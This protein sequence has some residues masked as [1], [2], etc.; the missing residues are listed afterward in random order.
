M[1]IV[2]DQ[3]LFFILL[4]IS[5]LCLLIAVSASCTHSFSSKKGKIMCNLLQI[6]IWSK[7]ILL[8]LANLS[9]VSQTHPLLHN[10]EKCL[11]CN[12]YYFLSLKMT[13]DPVMRDL[14]EL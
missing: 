7:S 8:L 11:G 10:F 9:C 14:R 4:M 12:S 1:F 13:R 3:I 5:V 6:K 2:F